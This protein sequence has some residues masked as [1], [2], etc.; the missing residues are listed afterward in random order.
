MTS[1]L[2]AYTERTLLVSTAHV[3]EATRLSLDG[4]S[5]D[6]A[7]V[8]FM[9]WEYGWSIPTWQVDDDVAEQEAQDL[10]PAEVVALLRFARAH[11]FQWVRFDP[12]ADVLQ[13]F[14]TFPWEW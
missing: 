10:I 2:T 7:S 4:L 3:T 14:L 6:D 12:D 11:G 5:P 9:A 13:P 1:D 8:S